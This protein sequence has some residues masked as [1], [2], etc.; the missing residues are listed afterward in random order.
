M[1]PETWYACE[2]C[3]ATRRDARTCDE[4]FHTLLA[5]EY[6]RPELRQQ[7]HLLV[8]AYHLQ[9]PR[10]YSPEG[11]A[12]ARQMLANFLVGLSSAAARARAQAVLGPDRRG[13]RLTGTPTSYGSYPSRP[14]WPV[15]VADVIASGIDDAATQVQRWART[16]QTALDRIERRE[17]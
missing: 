15:T 4:D 10:L 6:E 9:H 14:E 1:Q 11:L 12:Y 13:W 16:T 17:R 7:H 5:W 2:A 3:G 8:L